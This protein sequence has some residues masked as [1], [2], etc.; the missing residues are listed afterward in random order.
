MGPGRL[1]PLLALV[2]ACSRPAPPASSAFVGRETCAPCHERQAKLYTG[3]RHDLAMQPANAATVL[4]DFADASFE[5][6]GVRSNFFRRAGKYFVHTDGPD[7][8]LADFE[9][10]YV[11]GVYPLQQYLI[12]FPDGRYQALS[13]AWDARPKSEGGQRWFHLYPSEAVPAG[14]ILHW[15][16]PAQNWNF[17]CAECHSTNLEKRWDAKTQRYSTRWSEIDVSCEACH[18][19]GAAHVAWAKKAKADPRSPEADAE[20]SLARGL[21][22]DLRSERIEWV[23]DP[24]TGIAKPATPPK[25]HTQIEMCAR[26]HARRSQLYED[27]VPGKPLLETHKPALLEEGL[28][29]ADGQ[30]EEEVYEYGSFLQSR[31]YA[32]GVACGN[33]H[34]PHSGKI[35]G[36][37]D[38][39]CKH[40]HAP[41]RF[42]TPEHH[43]HKLDGKGAS[44]VECHMPT[45][46]YMV[47]D[48]RRDHS[49]RVPRPDLTLELGT[50]NA[51]TPCHA[52][53]N[54]SWAQDAV[55]AWF[56]KG[57][58]TKPHPG[59]A[60]DAGRRGLPAAEAE[61][62][63]LVDD[64]TQSGIVRASAVELLARCLSTNSLPAIERALED[65]DGLVR[66][67]ALD[68][69]AVVPP[70]ERVRLCYAL[71]SDPLRG[72]RIEAASALAG[73]AHFLNPEQRKPFDAALA[74]YRAAQATNSDRP[75]SYAN[76]GSI[77]ARLGD[78]AAARRAYEDG[79]RVA[80]WFAG[81]WVNLAD[82]CREE[83]DEAQ[84]ESVLRRGLAAAADKAPLHQALGLCL[85]R[86]Q[87]LPEALPELKSAVEL[88]PGDTRL[89]YVYGIAL[90]SAGKQV[91]ARAV[92]A[93][94]LEKQPADREL[95]FA[96]ATLERDLGNLPRAREYAARLLVATH[97]DP[98]ARALLEELQR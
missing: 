14:D 22:L 90:S 38:E 40:C 42:A 86:T 13:I 41:E 64:K 57:R 20:D 46:D 18:G 3:S 60:L 7:G 77:A 62:A 78:R 67:A 52:D 4:G 68:A 79:L 11:F 63:A 70:P 51:C 33:C 72:V 97:G 74:E 36:A 96:L 2:G 58:W 73:E 27:S 45:R 88:A 44:C 95:L 21:V 71:L 94:A 6:F 31:M 19:P 47:I 17:M 32:M 1:L 29:F 66:S 93:A 92:L 89:A 15:T 55:A 37:A 65:P 53:K 49:L 48:A 23:I 85:A 34:D 30:Q 26:C 76:L 91:E 9:I 28:Y 98:S 12:P 8:K 5:H 39:T 80:A 69:L 81:L 84:C 61:L 83:G 50:P 59:R 43:H 10:A 75:E 87:R 24:A 16:G 82:L 35:E 54:A 25:S 56:P